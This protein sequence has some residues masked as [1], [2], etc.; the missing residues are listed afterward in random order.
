MTGQCARFFARSQFAKNLMDR[1]E[2]GTLFF[3]EADY[4][5]DIADF[6]HGWRVDPDS[7]QNIVLGGGC[8]PIDLLRWFAGD[9]DEVHAVANKMVFPDTIPMEHD[10]A[11]LNLRF[12]GGAIGKC[13]IA[14]GCSRPYSLG[15]SLYGD[16]GTLV[17]EQLFLKRY[18]GVQDFMDVPLGPHAHEGSNLFDDQ[19]QHLIECLDS[20][21][22]PMADVVEGAKTVATCLAGAESIQTG[23]PV[24]VCNEF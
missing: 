23:K 15:L 21:V 19:A 1:G 7:P 22:Q 10:C 20:G 11:L 9:V 6:L 18:A 14:V 24:K 17:N 16:E 5:H 2:L 12:A 3:A 8:H 4:L 13:L